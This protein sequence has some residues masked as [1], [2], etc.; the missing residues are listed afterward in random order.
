MA[1]EECFNFNN[2]NEWLVGHY[3]FSKIQHLKAI[4]RKPRRLPNMPLIPIVIIITFTIGALV[5]GS[6]HA[7]E[8]EHAPNLGKKVHDFILTANDGSEYPLA[9]HKGKLIL[10]VNTASRCGFTDQYSGLQQLY[11]DYKDQ[12]LTVIALPSNDFHG[13]RTWH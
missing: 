2:G 5:I 1:C 6:C 12:G 9:Q 8:D 3:R 13:P 10:L 7:A 11:T 4:R